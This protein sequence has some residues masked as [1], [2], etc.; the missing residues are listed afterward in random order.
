MTAY[1]AMPFLQ[2]IRKHSKIAMLVLL[3]FVAMAYLFLPSLRY[4]F[5]LSWVYLFAIGYLYVNLSKKWKLFY[6]GLC[7][8]V[9]IYL[10]YLCLNLH[11]EGYRH[12]YQYTYR[13]IHD[14]VGVFVVIVGVWLLSKV[15]ELKVP[16]FVSFLD[17]YSYQVFIV[18]FIIM[19]GPF[20]MAHITPNIGTNIIIMLMVTVV[21]TYLFVKVMNLI[22][23]MLE[24]K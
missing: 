24:K 20:S 16:K 13:L 7:S 23:K 3:A 2:K 18:H 4:V 1:F 21:A 5:V 19:C 11:W 17:K 15:K 22:N 10:V 8:V 6:L 14:V 9:L 12:P